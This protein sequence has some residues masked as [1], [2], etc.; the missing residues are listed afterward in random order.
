MIYAE[1][2]AWGF[3]I[4]NGAIGLAVFCYLYG[5]VFAR[6]FLPNPSLISSLVLEALAKY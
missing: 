6:C 1:Y 2:V 4:L 3:L 5:M